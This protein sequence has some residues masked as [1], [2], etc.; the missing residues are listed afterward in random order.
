VQRHAA[1]VL[2][3]D[4]DGDAFAAS[5]PTTAP[6]QLG[7]APPAQTTWRVTVFAACFGWK[8]MLKLAVR[9]RPSH[10]QPVKTVTW[11]VVIENLM[12]K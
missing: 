8:F 7:H 3:V 1:T 4:D 9:I 11:A 6:A 5:R 10:G 12:I 2:P